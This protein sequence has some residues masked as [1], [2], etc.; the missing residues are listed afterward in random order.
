LHNIVASSILSGVLTN[1][2]IGTIDSFQ[3]R[4]AQVGVLSLVM[5]QSNVGF[6]D[7]GR[8]NVALTRAKEL[9][10]VGSREYWRKSG[11]KGLQDAA[12]VAENFTGEGDE[13]E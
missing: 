11:A 8:I 6:I 13:D 3:G 12:E 1:V 2:E 7:D 10:V 5:T 9:F 4:E